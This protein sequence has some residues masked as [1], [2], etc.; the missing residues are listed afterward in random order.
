ME[1]LRQF[2]RYLE[3][4][5]GYSSHTIKNYELDIMDFINYC[6]NNKLVIYKIKYFD[7]KEYLV[8]LYDKKYKGTT[9]SRKISSLRAFYTFL[10]G[11]GLVDRNIFKYISTPKKEKLLPKYITNED[12]NAIFDVPDIS[13]PIGQRNRLILELLYGS[14]IRVSELCNIKVKDID[15][16]NKTIRILGKGSKTRIVLYGETCAEILELYLS[17]GRE[18]L[19]NKKNNEYLIIGAY[20]KDKPLT[21][22]SVQLL[23]NDIIEKASINKKI[24]PHV[25]RH[26]FA[27]HLLNEGCDILIVKELL[28]HSSLDTTGIYTHVSN[29]R[30][31]KVYLDSHPRVIKK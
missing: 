4:E 26:T 13:S 9:I 21:T 6:N 12:I 11:N 31:R 30:L 15:L 19:L 23:M 7:V 29:E 2:V 25:L 28:G 16:N 14:G 20:K 5:R 1:D 3:N 17:D 10:Y 27:T 22:R 24:T 18:T 8:K